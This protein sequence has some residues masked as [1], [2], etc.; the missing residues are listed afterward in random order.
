MKKIYPFHSEASMRRCAEELAVLEAEEELL[1]RQGQ[2]KEVKCDHHGI[3]KAEKCPYC[4][5]TGTVMKFIREYMPAEKYER[6]CD[7]RRLFEINGR[8]EWQEKKR[9]LMP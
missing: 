7:L 3:K 8:A 4:K 6:L 5:G 9:K 2:W 1:E